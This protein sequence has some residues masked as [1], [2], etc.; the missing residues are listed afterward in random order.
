MAEAENNENVA[1]AILMFAFIIAKEEEDEKQQE[2]LFAIG[3]LWWHRPKRF[4]ITTKFKDRNYR[5]FYSAV[6]DRRMRRINLARC[7]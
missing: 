1:F 4:K 6:V 3:A 2:Q 5:C 7:I